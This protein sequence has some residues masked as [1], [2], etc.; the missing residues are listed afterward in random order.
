VTRA[1]LQRVVPKQRANTRENDRPKRLSP[2]L[3]KQLIIE[4]A[5]RFFAEHGFEGSTPDLA[6]RLGITQPL[7]YR[8]F[9]NKDDLIQHAYEYAFPSSLYYPKWT[10]LLKQEGIPNRDRL[11]EFYCDYAEVLLNHTFLRLSLW[12]RLSR[13]H[14]DTKYGD[15][16]R[17]VFFPLIIRALRS[18]C[19]VSLDSPPTETE[20]E[21][22]QTLHGSIYHLAFRRSLR[23]P[24]KGDIRPLVTLKVDLFLNG[25][26]A[27][28]RPNT[29]RS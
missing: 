5:T 16:L 20:M 14:L 4:E 11:I 3:R 8:Y 12:A 2:D 27:I 29:G 15:T 1:A 7:L 13:A 17:K 26:N 22:V 9:T 25:V 6:R 28:M 24:M 10:A 21:A 23:E 18:T 19:G